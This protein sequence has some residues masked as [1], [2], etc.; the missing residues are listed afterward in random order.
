MTQPR[1]VIK[2]R[3]LLRNVNNKYFA[4]ALDNINNII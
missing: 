1:T 3:H 4:A 2:N